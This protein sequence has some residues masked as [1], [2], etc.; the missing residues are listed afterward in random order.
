MYDESHLVSRL[1]A[2]VS[3]GEIEGKGAGKR[4][5]LT[6]STRATSG[7]VLGVG[8]CMT[9]A[10][11][12]QKSVQRGERECGT[13]PR[14]RPPKRK[15]VAGSDLRVHDSVSVGRMAVDVVATEHLC[16]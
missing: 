10:E 6:A 11:E 15:Q 1:R 5:P 7:V 4:S 3:S 8:G 12:T 16:H 9:A 2:V 14:H 13:P